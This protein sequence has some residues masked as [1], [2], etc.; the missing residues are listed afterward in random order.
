M[1]H[2][3]RVP[4]AFETLAS[5]LESRWT[6]RA[7]TPEAVPEET[8]DRRPL[9]RRLTLELH[10]EIEEER[11]DRREVLDDDADVVDPAD[12]HGREGIP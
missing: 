7:Y 11:R 10:S 12:R 1:R 6:C 8:V 3:G 2:S 4:D 9:D 5:L